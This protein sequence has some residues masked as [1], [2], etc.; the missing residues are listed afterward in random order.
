MVRLLRAHTDWQWVVILGL[1]IS[2]A[3]AALSFYTIERWALGLRDR[4]GSSKP[5]TQPAGSRTA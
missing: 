2:A 5:V 3:F 4:S 1:P